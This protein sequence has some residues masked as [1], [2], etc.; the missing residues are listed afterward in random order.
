MPLSKHLEEFRK[1]L[2]LALVAI[3]LGAVAGWFL[4]DPVMAFIQKPLGTAQ[5]AQLNFQT[6]GAAFDLRLKVSIWL[7]IILTCPWWIYQLAAF[8]GPGMN[9][10]EKLYSVSFGFFGSLLFLGGAASGVWIAPRAVQILN[11]FTPSGSLML[12]RADSYVTFYMRL[13]VAFGLSFLFPL[14]LVAANFLGVLS[15]R[16]M[17]GAWRWITL[18]AFTFAAIANPLPSPWPM[19][20]QAAFLIGL[21]LLAV[22]VSALREYFQKRRRSKLDAAAQVN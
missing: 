11:S 19:V 8:I 22:A 13:V 5:G 3:S 18:G 14:A 15:A 17:L 1:R 10:K 2:I 20:I 7:G 6:I 16:K 9:R 12:I 4:Y 21:Y